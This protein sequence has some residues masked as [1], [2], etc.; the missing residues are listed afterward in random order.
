MR[1]TRK[2]VITEVDWKSPEAFGDRNINS[3][4]AQIDI[5]EE[6]FGIRGILEG[7]PFSQGWFV[8]LPFVMEVEFADTRLGVQ[9]DSDMV[10]F[11]RPNED[12]CVLCCGDGGI[13]EC[14]ADGYEL[15][16]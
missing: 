13:L 8:R 10:R 3:V 11:S 4:I 16:A 15:V 12:F 2:Y 6:L 14:G 5:Q 1:N 9:S 7:E